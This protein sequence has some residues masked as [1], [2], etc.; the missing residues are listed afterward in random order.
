MMLYGSL[1]KESVFYAAGIFNGDG[2]DGLSSG[3]EHDEP[4]A[5]ARLVISPFKNTSNRMLN[6]FQFGFS[7]A[8]ATIEPMNMDLNVKT[9][10]MEGI[11]RSIYVLSHN[12]KFGVLQDAGN[13]IRGGLETAWAFRSLAVQ[14]EYFYLKFTD[15]E[16]AGSTPKDADFYSWYTGAMWWFTGEE[17]L[18]ADGVMKPVIPKQNFNPDEGTFGAVGLGLRLEHFEGDETWINPS[19]SVSVRD[20]DAFSV[21]LTW[22]LFPMHRFIMDYTRTAFSDSI[23]VRVRPDGHV[24]YIDKENVL[25]VRFSIDF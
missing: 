5:V 15:L 16:A 4:E 22:M 9:T 1:L 20:A 12:T 14:G 7:G 18:L 2:N 11:S 13:R 21:A 24:D 17:P 19:A 8:Y 25:T 10:G 3:S 23:R 6:P